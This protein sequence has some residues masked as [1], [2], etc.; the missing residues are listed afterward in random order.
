M[1]FLSIIIFSKFSNG[2]ENEELSMEPSAAE[3]KGQLFIKAQE[4]INWGSQ[5]DIEGHLT[6][7]SQH[8]IPN[9][10]EFR[11]NFTPNIKDFRTKEYRRESPNMYLKKLDKLKKEFHTE[12]VKTKEFKFSD[13]LLSRYDLLPPGEYEFFIN[14]GSIRS[15]SLKLKIVA[16]G[17][18]ADFANF[19]VQEFCAGRLEKAFRPFFVLQKAEET[20][21]EGT[22]DPKLEK[23][24]IEGYAQYSSKFSVWS[25]SIKDVYK[26]DSGFEEYSTDVIKKS[27]PEKLKVKE[28]LVWFYSRIFKNSN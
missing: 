24:W 12:L 22:P 18:R 20:N 6:F 15:N 28:Q 13:T 11:T 25:N 3:S 5:I 10:D 7:K 14:F 26:L 8:E 27:C 16:I 4:E 17:W 1:I 9:F 19:V 21:C 2:I 23:M